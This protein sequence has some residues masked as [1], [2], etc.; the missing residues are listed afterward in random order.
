[1]YKESSSSN[2]IVRFSKTEYVLFGEIDGLE[3]ASDTSSSSFPPLPETF[4]TACE[5]FHSAVDV[6]GLLVLPLYQSLLFIHVMS[7]CSFFLEVQTF[8]F[9]FE[10]H[11]LL[12]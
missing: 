5:C 2:K 10:P 7:F 3:A 11:L 12:L 9:Q 8:S 4:S 1:M 6:V